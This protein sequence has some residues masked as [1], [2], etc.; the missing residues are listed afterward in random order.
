MAEMTGKVVLVTGGTS[1]IGRAA[2]VLFGKQGAAVVIAARGE[3]RGR[4]ALAELR[5][6][7][8]AAE[9]VA[10][11]VS[12]PR[13][14]ERLAAT[15]VQTFGRLDFAFNNAASI[16][17]RE[18]KSTAELTEDEFD[19]SY[20]MN[21]RSVWLCMKHELAHMMRQARGGAIVNTSSINGLGGCAFAAPYAVAKAGVLALTKS[22]AQEYAAHGIRVNAVVA[23]AFDTPMLRGV[24]ERRTGGDAAKTGEAEKAYADFVPLRRIGRPEEAA[25]AAVWLCSDAASYVTGNSLIVDGGMTAW[26]R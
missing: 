19:R 22:A 9:F 1:G 24:L 2:A 10:A 20:E 11:D 17:P 18:F 21:L 4:E 26:A 16:E 12:K 3:E 14:V 15:A 6:M 8:V 7:G 25:A 23:G 5:A 13:D